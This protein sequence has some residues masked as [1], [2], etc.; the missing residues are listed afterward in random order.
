MKNRII[1]DFLLRYE[2]FGGIIATNNPPALTF[3]DKN[4]IQELGRSSDLL[5]DETDNGILSAPIEAHYAIT[6][7][8]TLCCS[9]CYMSSSDD[10]T[11]LND[12]KEDVHKAI[13]IAKI[14]SDMGIFHVALGGGE[15][16]SIPWFF[17]LAECF[18]K[19]NVIPN[20]TTN[21]HLITPENIEKCKVFGQVNI[22][23]DMIT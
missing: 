21:G 13:S 17:E 23:L 15:S 8:C 6:D 7:Y 16:F 9:G 14:L 19:Q 11:K 1:N 2:K 20:V 22:S 18:R 10:I 12:K 4:Y 3:V 5:W